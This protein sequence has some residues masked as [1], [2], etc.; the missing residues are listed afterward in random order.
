MADALATFQEHRPRLFGIAYRMLGTA[1]EADDVLQDAW[2][3]WQGADSDAVREPGAFLA[4]TVTRLAINEL[5]SARA[6]DGLVP[7]IVEG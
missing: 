6:L 7:P 2:L 3:R 5:S 4:T 1:T